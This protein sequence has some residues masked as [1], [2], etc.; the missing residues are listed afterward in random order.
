[1]IAIRM[2]LIMLWLITATCLGSGVYM[3]VNN[4]NI[5]YTTIGVVFNSLNLI[6]IT[7]VTAL[8]FRRDDDDT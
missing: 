4:T 3:L 8:T 2:I 5:V 6:V 7:V 1:M